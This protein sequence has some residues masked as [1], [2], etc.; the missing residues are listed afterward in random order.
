MSTTPAAYASRCWFDVWDK[1]EHRAS[2]RM[3]S[4][5]GRVSARQPRVSPAPGMKQTSSVFSGPS[6]ERTSCAS[7]AGAGDPGASSGSSR[8]GASC[9][10]DPVEAESPSCSYI[11]A[12]GNSCALGDAAL[13]TERASGTSGWLATERCYRRMRRMCCCVGRT[14]APQSVWFRQRY[15]SRGLLRFRPTPRSCGVV[16]VVRDASNLLEK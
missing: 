11:A 7:S 5:W 6:N 13:H 3:P 10:S 9:G 1:I 8:N 14:E 16:N 4:S 15:E 2:A 12:I